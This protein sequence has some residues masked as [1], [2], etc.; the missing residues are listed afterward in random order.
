MVIFGRIASARGFFLGSG[1]VA[2]QF[3]QSRVAHEATFRLHDA[4]PRMCVLR[5]MII[6]S[7]RKQLYQLPGKLKPLYK[8][9]RLDSCGPCTAGRGPGAVH[10]GGPR[11]GAGLRPCRAEPPSLMKTRGSG[12]HV[13]VLQHPGERHG[14]RTGTTWRGSVCPVH[15][16]RR[17]RRA[18]NETR[19]ARG[20]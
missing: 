17:P 3:P 8:S 9:S 6:H 5:K 7:A 13:G 19:L 2:V 1:F 4:F 14:S 15:V 18:R 20:Q 16:I 10:R 11:E 12:R